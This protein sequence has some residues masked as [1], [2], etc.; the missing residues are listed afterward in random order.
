MTTVHLSIVFTKIIS[1]I[2]MRRKNKTTNRNKKPKIETEKISKIQMIFKPQEVALMGGFV[3]WSDG[4]SVGRSVCLQKISKTLK[5]RFREYKLT[6]LSQ[7][8]LVYDWGG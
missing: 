3:G 5:R 1:I 2:S 7:P 8:S 4:R 6:K